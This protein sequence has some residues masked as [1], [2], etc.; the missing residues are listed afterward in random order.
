MCV[1]GVGVQ[2]H[3][4]WVMSVAY[5]KDGKQLVSGKNKGRGRGESNKSEGQR[6]GRRMIMRVMVSNCDKN[7]CCVKHCSNQPWLQKKIIIEHR[8]R[9]D[10]GGSLCP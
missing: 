8:D 7:V 5:S 4:G 6:G 3:T 10:T 9:C 2:G 1:D